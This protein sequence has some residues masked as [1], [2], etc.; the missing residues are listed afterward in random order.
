MWARER[1]NVELQGVYVDQGLKPCS[2][3][4]AS[5]L[6]HVCDCGRVASSDG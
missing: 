3:I 1:G 6:L 5:F 4:Q 2:G